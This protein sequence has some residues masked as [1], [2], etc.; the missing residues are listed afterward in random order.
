MWAP[1]NL[2]LHSRL[3]NYEA[4][5]PS[6]SLVQQSSV[7]MSCWRQVVYRN[8]EADYHIVLTLG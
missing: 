6:T 7:E 2:L 3:I 8:P 5:R 1:Q 4:G